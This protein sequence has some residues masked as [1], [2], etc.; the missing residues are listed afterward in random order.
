LRNPG[1]FDY[2]IQSSTAIFSDIFEAKNIFQIFSKNLFSTH[3]G[4]RCGPE[5]QAAGIRQQIPAERKKLRRICAA[6]RL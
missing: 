2:K 1:A 6:V 4:P 3:A 5:Q